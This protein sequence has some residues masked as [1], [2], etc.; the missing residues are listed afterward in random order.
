MFGV[1]LR[2]LS[3]QLKVDDAEQLIGIDRLEEQRGKFGRVQRADAVLDFM[4]RH[5][6][7]EDHWECPAVFLKIAQHCE[8]IDL[9]HVK[10]QQDQIYRS[11][12]ELHNR[13]VAIAGLVH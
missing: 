11:T 7:K 1:E 10:I 3:A 12:F 5:S 2:E 4:E 9:R 13:G 8:S 6:G